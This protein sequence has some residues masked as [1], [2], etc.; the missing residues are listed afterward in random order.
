MSFIEKILEG[1]AMEWKTLEEV[2]TFRRGSF[3]Q[4][5]G[6]PGWY[7]GEGA[8]PFV[9]VVDVGSN[10]RLV[11]KTKN[12][13]SILA[14]P[15]SVFVPEGTVIV[16][17]QGSIGRVAITQY[18]AYVDRTL[19]IFEEF[20]IEINK[21][22][23]AYQIEN[24]F[25]SKKET[26]RGSTIKTITKEEFGKF[27]IPIPPLEI[28]QKIVNILD[29]FKE[30]TAQLVAELTAELA[31]RKQ[32]YHYYR[33]RLLTFEEDEVE[34]KMLGEVGELVRG[35]G[36]PKSDFTDIGVPAIHYGQI[37][38]YYSTF[39]EKTISFVSPETARKLKK[40]NKG[41]VIITNTSE[42]FKDVGKSVVYLGNESGVTGGH[43]TIFR[44]F[45]TL[46]G[47]FF[48]YY[49]QTAA[50]A[51]KKGKYA[52]GTKVIDV[53]ANDLAKIILPIP[54]IK[55]QERIISILDKFDTLYHS[56]CE[57][58]PKE[59]ELRQKQ[60]QYYSDMLLNL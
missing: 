19:A 14:Q 28:Q 51:K 5:Y 4:P 54:S 56:I 11:E 6:E 18:D 53:S 32:Q 9:Q 33:E 12:L 25:K 31:A 21:K 42:N 55:E 22:Y 24:I 44:P 15:K 20:K 60:Y 16:T 13:I 17:L 34:W 38:T 48:A 36:L 58:L 40:F 7:D 43:A 10:M 39:T 47:K 37:Y 52:K 3:P 23:F 46:I 50:F 29:S 26:A 8:M 1:V 2:S 59:M 49:T 57:S 41:D 30:L 35:N 45:E 27:P